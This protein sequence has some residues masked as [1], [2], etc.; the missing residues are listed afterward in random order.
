MSGLSNLYLERL[1]FPWCKLFK[2]VFSCDN[3]TYFPD[4]K[5]F[6]CIVN[7]AKQREKGTHFVCIFYDVQDIYLFDSFGFQ[8]NNAYIKIFLDFYSEK[9]HFNPTQIQSYESHFCRY[10]CALFTLLVEQNVKMQEM[11]D[12]FWS[13][14][15]REND[16]L[17]TRILEYR[18]TNIKGV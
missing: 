6:S 4:Q 5:P 7:L 9:Q 10:Y 16:E 1:L 3:L 14:P 17:L 12:L 15:C 11:V 18:K 8:L 13:F 2:G